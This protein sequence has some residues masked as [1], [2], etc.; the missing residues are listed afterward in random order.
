MKGG[1]LVLLITQNDDV[2]YRYVR[3]QFFDRLYADGTFS[4]PRYCLD[5]DYRE[6]VRAHDERN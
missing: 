1:S 4:I 2:Y 3:K 6:A 5:P